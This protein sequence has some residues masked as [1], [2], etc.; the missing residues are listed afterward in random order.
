MHVCVLYVSDHGMDKEARVE[1]KMSFL[2]FSSSSLLLLLLSLLLLFSLF[3]EV[4]LLKLKRAVLIRL[5]G[6]QA[7]GM[8]LCLWC[9]HYGC[10]LLSTAL[11]MGS[12]H[13][14]SAPQLAQ[15]ERFPLSHLPRPNF[16]SF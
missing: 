5:D 2:S 11:H 14:S 4:I 8:P 13:Q 3:L 12:G 6:Q 7:L 15:Q 1:C 9:W 16:L 10:V